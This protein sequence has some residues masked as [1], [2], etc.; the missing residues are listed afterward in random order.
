MSGASQ[1][2]LALVTG[3]LV[4]GLVIRVYEI[5]QGNKM[6]TM[7]RWSTPFLLPCYF[8]GLVAGV[9]LIGFTILYLL[10]VK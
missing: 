2:L 8:M 10:G 4:V 3:S 6:D 7:E 9:L 1:T 5:I